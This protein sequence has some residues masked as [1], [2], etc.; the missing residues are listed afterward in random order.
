[1][2][3]DFCSRLTHVHAPYL[4]PLHA[5][6]TPGRRACGSVSSAR[7]LPSPSLRRRRRLLKEKYKPERV[8]ARRPSGRAGKFEYLIAWKLFGVEGDT[9]EAEEHVSE[10]AKEYD[11]QYDLPVEMCLRSMREHFY[12]VMT[13]K[14][15]AEW[16]KKDTILAGVDPATIHRILRRLTVR[17]GGLTPHRLQ[18]QDGGGKR[19]TWLTLADMDSVSDLVGLHHEH[20]EAGLGALRIRHGTARDKNLR[21]I[22]APLLI[23]YAEP[24]PVSGKV[25]PKGYKLTLEY[26]TW[27]FINPTG[28]HEHPPSTQKISTKAEGN[29]VKH[30]KRLVRE[31]WATGASWPNG[32]VKR[33]G[34]SRPPQPGVPAWADLPPSR[35]ALTVRESMPR[36]CSKRKRD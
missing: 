23:K 16:G 15:H 7:P 25:I 17:R 21:M 31:P 18:S 4:T 24:L 1:M 29:I 19:A 35:W 2:I 3:G 22:G 28:D 36:V 6:V 32:P 14:K 8:L 10:L 12:R 26:S 34:L 13:D 11:K 5:A 20:P 27:T 9:W 30:V 33:H